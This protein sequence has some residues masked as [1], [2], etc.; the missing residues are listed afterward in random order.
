MINDS[1]NRFLGVLC[2]PL[3][4]MES[5][6]QDLIQKYLEAMEDNNIKE[7]K[8]VR[9]NLRSQLVG[10]I[11]QN[12]N[13]YSYDEIYLYLEKCYLYDVQEFKNTM[14]LYLRTMERMAKSLIS[15]RDGQIVFKYWKN[16][17]DK[18]LFGGFAENN[19]IM[20]FHSL[21]C[22]VPMDV[23]AILYMVL[24]QEEKNINCL[25]GFYGNIEVAD[26]QLSRVLEGGVAE[27]HL[28]KGVSR[29]FPSIWN[30]LM[31]PLTVEK[32]KM[33]QQ[34]RFV[35][36]TAEQN[37]HMIY[38]ILGCGI[39]RAYLILTKEKDLDEQ[40]G[41]E[42]RIFVKRFQEGQPFEDFFYSAFQDKENRVKEIIAYYMQLWNDLHYI[43]SEETLSSGLCKQI[44][45]DSV[46]V[47]TLDENIFLYYMLYEIYRQD[48]KKCLR[49]QCFLQYLRVRNFLFHV[50]VQ[51][52]TIKG[53]DYFQ[54]EHYGINSALNHANIK[55]FWEHAIREQFQNQYLSKIEFRTSMPESYSDF[56]KD[57]TN[58]LNAYKKILVTEYC[59]EGVPVKRIPRAGLVIHF[60]KQE[61]EIVS[62]KCLQNGRMEC[63]YLHFGQIQKSYQKQIEVFKQLRSKVVE[64]SKFLVGI[65]AASLENATPVW[66]FAPIY[67][68]ARDSGIELIGKDN[69][70]GEYMQSLG[71]TFHAGEDFRHILSGL[72]RIDEVVE[73]LKFHAGD[74]IGHG[75]ALGVPVAKWKEQ[76][77]VIIIP[78]IE[79]LEN[80]LWAYDAL[81]K[82]YSD[83]QAAILTYME[84]QIYELSR[85]IYGCKEGGIRIELLI[86]GYHQLFH[87]SENDFESVDW[88]SVE[89]NL[90]KKLRAKERIEWNPSLLA[91]ARHC[92]IFVKEMERPIHCEVTEQDVI[93]IEKLQEIMKKKL[94]RKG[95]V[96]EVNPSSNTAIADLE[97]LEDS[98]F[99]QMNQMNG[100]QN[101]I[102]CI[103]SDDPA[104]F[105]TN[106][107]NELAYIYYGMLE[108]GI[109]REMALLWIER[110]QKN[111]INS[112]FI[113]REESDEIFVKK[114]IELTEKM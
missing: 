8:K 4:S 39:V 7:A 75:I 104:V 106:V 110:I 93:I 11:R 66:V 65:D 27:N 43:F 86:D 16:K 15:H 59:E 62:E 44:A 36:G 2:Y 48:S 108:K 99:Y 10:Y 77:P 90:C 25:D 41:R 109:S 42:I 14:K 113:R 56:K 21:N 79:A 29:T 100:D 95:I 61:D 6:Q 71:F 38:Y 70:S 23:I 12:Y 76:N 80:Y 83:F 24:N 5:F 91:A 47:H 28:H 105:N 26:K 94:S 85:R 63:S 98:Q 18:E 78:N 89:E 73:H 88:I 58:F 72:R 34:T 46:V 22:H 107:S 102:V 57:V 82:N 96:V 37:E 33:L 53:L 103:N 60:L 40:E 92:K 74:R 1:I 87:D 112:S 31:E 3:T 51:Q 81:S 20:L 45:E 19:K 111:G 50:S 101:V 17:E 13:L 69:I 54:Q 64:V 84:K 68:K 67:E 35:N 114:L 30:S 32:G 55:N 97:V 52:K 49:K 9:D